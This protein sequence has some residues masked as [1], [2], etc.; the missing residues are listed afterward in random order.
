MVNK[1]KVMNGQEI[2]TNTFGGRFGERVCVVVD[3]PYC[4]RDGKKFK[5]T[6][7]EVAELW[8]DYFVQEYGTSD[9][10]KILEMEGLA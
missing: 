10:T 2:W 3:Y 6:K 9:I 5:P 4:V 7:E 8:N 1:L